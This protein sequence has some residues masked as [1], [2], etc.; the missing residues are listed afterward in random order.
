MVHL[1]LE[2]VKT[3]PIREVTLCGEANGID[4]VPGM[5]RPTVFGLDIPLVG[6][7]VELSPDDSRVE[8]HIFLD[9]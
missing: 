7:R 8:C 5:R 6:L 2:S 3:F 1:T 9:V 4:Q